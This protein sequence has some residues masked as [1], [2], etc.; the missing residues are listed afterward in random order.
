MARFK[1]IAK[2]ITAILCLFV[3][4][5]WISSCSQ[6][7]DLKAVK[8][9]FYEQWRVKAE[10]SKGHSAVEPP[11]VDEEPFEIAG[12]EMIEALEPEVERS[13]PTR[14]ISLKMKSINVSVLLRALAK[15]ANQN[16]ILS[17][18]VS[19]KININIHQ[20]PWDQVFMGILRTHNLSYAW[21]GE[22]IR[23]MTADDLEADIRRKARKRDLQ[24]VQSPV[25][26]IVSV[27]FMVAD[28]LKENL[29]KF[30]SIDKSGNP[31]GS[32]LVDEHSNSLIVQALKSD[33]DNILAI[34][35]RLDRPTPQVLIEAYIVEAN[36]DVARELGVQWGGIYAGKSGHKRAI[37]TGQQTGTEAIPLNEPINVT[38]GSVVNLP[39]AGLGGFDPMTLGLVYTRLGEYLLS[40]QLSA[41]QDQGK[42][43]ILSSPSITTLDN[44]NAYIESGA[45]V[46]YQ[47]VE[48]GEVKVEYKK[49][50]LRLD[51]TPHVIDGETLKMIIKVNKDEPDF[52]RT[53]L[54]NPTIITK[55]AETNVIQN[56]GQTI[57][58]GGLSKESSA[59]SKTGTPFL[60]D[61]PGL[62]YL[63]KRKSSADQMEEL[64][65]FIT[66]HILKP[67]ASG[68]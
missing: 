5:A 13:L 45:D 15:A 43:H 6:K 68:G 1:R 9:P 19:G 23:I 58:I 39:A 36:K 66:P 55:K 61:I 18:K 46:P 28:K 60:E 11:A 27:K 7:K 32:I 53:V 56:D 25:T 35:K 48:D 38:S 30:V 12:K 37:V 21:E 52:S 63:F 33:M 26:R 29:G 31:I 41:L 3:M 47:S 40:A 34:I 57:V 44:Q 24:M 50:V 8:D 51:V 22:I 17:E 16:I 64:L 59:R 67:R 49:A 4:A 2:F 42:L 65:I 62:G 54:G 20:A 14:K 10:E